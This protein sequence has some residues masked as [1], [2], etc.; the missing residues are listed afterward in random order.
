M[1]KH[2]LSKKA[3]AKAGIFGLSLA[4]ALG[5]ASEAGAAEHT[6]DG[7]YMQIHAGLGYYSMSA[8]SAGSEVSF[9]GVSFASAFQLGGSLAPG[10]VLGGS[11]VTDYVFSPSMSINDTDVPDGFGP[12][13]QYLFGIGPFIDFYPD[14]QGGLHFQG[15]VG[16][17]GVESSFEGD[18]S[19]NDPT[20]PMFGIGGG[21]EWW[22]GREWS[23]GAMAR[24]IYAP[25][26]YEDVSFP[27]IAPALLATFTYH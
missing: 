14:P 10:I 24:V 9:S 11:L 18:V 2:T 8:E 6:H 3:L 21:Y 20:G 13:S 23:I 1:A 4:A 22:V 7:F 19:G 16:F 26:S 25:L 5:F 27:T 17:G 12:T 15:M